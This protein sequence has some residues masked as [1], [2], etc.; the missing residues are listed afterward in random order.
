MTGR[1]ESWTWHRAWELFAHA[2]RLS[3]PFAL[4]HP[5]QARPVWEPPIDVFEAPGGFRVIVALPG[6]EAHSVEIALSGSDLVVVGE[7][8]RPQV[9]AHL[10]VLRLEIPHGRFE[11]RLELPPGTYRLESREMVDGCLVVS[12]ARI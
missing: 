2:E 1:K 8:S 3:R 4:R 6:V 11:R 10:K 12:F 7:R 9:C 5:A